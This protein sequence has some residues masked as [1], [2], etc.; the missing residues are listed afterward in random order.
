M[1]C[2]VYAVRKSLTRLSDFIH[3]S[4][5]DS[6]DKHIAQTVSGHLSSM[7]YVKPSDCQCFAS[8]VEGDTLILGDF[9]LQNSLPGQT[10]PNAIQS[11]YEVRRPCGTR[12]VFLSF[13]FKKIV[14][15]LVQQV[16]FCRHTFLLLECCKHPKRDNKQ[17]CRQEEQIFVKRHSCTFSS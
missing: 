8:Y 1:D 15:Q 5:L 3:T 9:Q 7:G 16:T 10:C 11:L 14:S 4:C 17:Q 2:I 12:Q 13:I 6:S